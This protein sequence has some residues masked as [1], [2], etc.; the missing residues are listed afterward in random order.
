M[1]VKF[2]KVF[3]KI[4]LSI[5]VSQ[6]K[7]RFHSVNPSFKVFLCGFQIFLHFKNSQVKKLSE[8][9]F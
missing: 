3:P 6:R 4:S 7:T 8:N 1:F 5:N 9:W 2:D